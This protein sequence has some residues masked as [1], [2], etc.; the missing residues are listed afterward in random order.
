[1]DFVFYRKE[2]YYNKV[3][4]SS[5]VA[6]VYILYVETVRINN[7]VYKMVL[8]TVLYTKERNYT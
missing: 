5:I 4:S 1:M 3:Q 7:I 6:N 2:K 8:N